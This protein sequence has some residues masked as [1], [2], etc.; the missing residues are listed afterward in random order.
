ME[1]GLIFSAFGWISAA[2]QMPG[3]FLIDRPGVRLVCGG[4]RFSWSLMTALP[5][6]ASSVGALS[7]LRLGVGAFEPPVTPSNN[8]VIASGFPE[9]ERASAIGIYSSA[10]FVGLACMT[11][12]L[13]HLQAAL[14]WRGLFLIT[15]I[16]GMIRARV[17]SV[18]YRGPAQHNGVSAAELR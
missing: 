16:A 11:P 5:A 2:L 15:G 17:W 10:L 1:R 7:G 4:G 3:S 13:F 14:G 12:L 6:L 8:R 18:F 9:Q